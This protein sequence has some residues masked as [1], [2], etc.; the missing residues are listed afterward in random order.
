MGYFC[1]DF[2][3]TA[4]EGTDKPWLFTS[5]CIGLK[6]CKVQLIDDMW[7]EKPGVYTLGLGFSASLS[8][9]LGQ[10]VFDIILQG[11]PVLQVLIYSKMQVLQ[12]E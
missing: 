10:R 9:S 12:I 3:N 5:G 2:R 6:Q 8:D 1:R 4:F 11:E 7:G